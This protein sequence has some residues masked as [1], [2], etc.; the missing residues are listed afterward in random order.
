MPQST[1]QTWYLFQAREADLDNVMIVWHLLWADS[2]QK[3]P[4]IFLLL[5]LM[6]H[7]QHEVLQV[8]GGGVQDTVVH[9]QLHARP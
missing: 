1:A 9:Q 5:H 2:V 4:R 6:H 8:I 7:H 3:G